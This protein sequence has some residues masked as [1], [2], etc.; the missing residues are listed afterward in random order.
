MHL[1]SYVHEHLSHRC[2]FVTTL[3]DKEIAIYHHRNISTGI[4]F[5]SSSGDV[6]AESIIPRQTDH[7]HGKALFTE[8]AWQNRGVC[9]SESFDPEPTGSN[10]SSHFKDFWEIPSHRVHSL[11]VWNLPNTK[12]WRRTDSLFN[13]EKGEATSQVSQAD[14]F[15]FTFVISADINLTRASDSSQQRPA[16]FESQTWGSLNTTCTCSSSVRTL[17]RPRYT[18]A[19]APW[20][21]RSEISHR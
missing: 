16:V 10:I 2:L 14:E 18:L 11:E 8:L 9:I 6:C 4:V 1:F 12:W 20:P 7:T 17:C 13:P 5:L 19:V 15:R 21:S 3:W